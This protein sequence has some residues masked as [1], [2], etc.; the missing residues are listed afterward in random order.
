MGHV[1]FGEF[2]ACYIGAAQQHDSHAHIATQ[3]A[4][5]LDGPVSVQSLSRSVAGDGVMISPRVEHT[6]RAGI[7]ERVAFLYVAPHVAL[8]RALEQRLG[9]QGLAPLDA[10]LVACFREHEDVRKQVAALSRELGAPA[11]RAALDPRLMRALAT[12]EA[13]PGVLGAIERAVAA[14]GLSEARL[15]V[16]AQSDLG[17]PL[18]QWMLWRKLERSMRSI[19]VGTSLSE[20]A[21]DAG[22]ADQAHLSRTMRRMFGITT[23]LATPALQRAIDSFKTPTMATLIMS[24]H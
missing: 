7:G 15:R 8:S 4:V 5:G 6:A 22:F 23:T 16:L 9:G 13:D 20:A 11:G 2:W 17:I 12:L 14:S 21:V 1:I 10:R 24:G 3:L 19:A 18:S